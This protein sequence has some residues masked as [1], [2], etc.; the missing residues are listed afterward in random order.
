MSASRLFA[1]GALCAVVASALTASAAADVVFDGATI[2][3]EAASLTAP[4]GSIS[5]GTLKV[6]GSEVKGSI[7][8]KGV[9][10]LDA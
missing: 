6:V 2:S 9:S 10:E 1:L 3:I 7:T 8:R 4:G 5:G